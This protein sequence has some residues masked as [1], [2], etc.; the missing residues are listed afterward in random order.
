M[1]ETIQGTL[2]LFASISSAMLGGIYFIFSNTVM[3]TLKKVSSGPEVMQVINRIIQNAGFFILFFGSFLSGIF[4]MSLSVLG[5]SPL[6]LWIVFG[7]LLLISAFLSTIFVNVPLNNVLDKQDEHS[8]EIEQIWLH[9]VDKWV[10]W[11]HLRTVLCSAGAV[12]LLIEL[13]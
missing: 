11:N 10:W 7:S 3:P 5:G 2:L 13:V 1:L 8:K 12:C 6:S 4:L 9:Y